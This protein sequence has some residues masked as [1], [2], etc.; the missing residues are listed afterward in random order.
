MDSCRRDPVQ[1]VQR[2]N[3][4]RRISLRVRDRQLYVPVARYGILAKSEIIN[5]KARIRLG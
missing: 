1:Y 2:L 3:R 4:R 5:E